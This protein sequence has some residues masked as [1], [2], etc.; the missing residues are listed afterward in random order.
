[1]TPNGHD[2]PRRTGGARRAMAVGAATTVVCSLPV[3][4]TGA[5]AVQLTEELGFGTVGIGA[6][7]GTFFATMALSSMYLGRV[8]DRLGAT[9]S[10]RL[11]AS[12][13]ALAALGIA[14]LSRNWAS[15]AGWLVVAGLS[16][17]LAQPAAN[18]MLINRVRAA[19]LGTAF[20]LKQSAPPTASMLAG[21][22]VP[23]VALTVGWRWAYALAAVA[24]LGVIVL[25]GPRPT[26][27]PPG[28]TRARGA[29]TE[30]LRD[31]PT[32]VV[33]ATGFGLAIAS[34]SAVLAYYVEAAVRGGGTPR[35]AGFVFAAASLSA[36]VVRL[37][38]GVVCDR[39]A[40]SPLRLSAALLATG[41]FGV[42][43]LTTG[44]GP[45]MTV[46]ILVALAGTWG[47]PGVFWFA[48]VGAY[49]DTPGRVTG[50]MAPAALG[51]IVG[52]IGFGSVASVAGYPTA[53][54][55]AALAA[56]LAATAMLFGARRLARPR[57]SR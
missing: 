49:P 25:V 54:I 5:M 44:G 38:A 53:W 29:R 11:A 45:A 7:V 12:G 33:L 30:P 56:L 24:A 43:L 2:S 42:G 31:R 8:A 19:R 10:L 3:F 46:G 51:G 32:L 39:S 35:Y 47:F 6:A 36:I 9:V 16:A 1:M 14:V 40:W 41:A 13:A 4:F 17:A 27:A 55:L 21:L 22:S 15:L 48:L 37:I 18:R 26:P 23:V 28:P 20:G 50:T 57:L 52:P 34:S